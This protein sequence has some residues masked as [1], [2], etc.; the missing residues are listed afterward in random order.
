MLTYSSSRV[1]TASLFSLLGLLAAAACG[2]GGSADESNGTGSTGATAG[3]TS[4]SG[5]ATASGATANNGGGGNAGGP[6][7][8]GG[9]TGSGAA[10]NSG[11]RPAVGGYVGEGGI[12]GDYPVSPFIVVDQ[13]GYLEDS[14]KVAVLRNP[15]QGFDADGEYQTATKYQLIDAG[16]GESVLDLTAEPWDEGK[17]HSQSGDQAAWIDFSTFKTPGTY[18]V[19]DVDAE[20]RSDAFR[21][22]PDVYRE[23]LRHAL[24]TFFYQ[25]A[26]FAKKAPFADEGW[27]DEASH[28]GPKQDKNA[29]L[30]GSTGD[31][32]TERDVS[33]G[34]YDAGDYNRY[35]PWSADYVLAMLRA[36]QER[37]SA[38]GDDLNIPESG[39][40]V[41]DILDEVRFG[42][43]QLKR[44]QTDEGGCLS[45][46][47][48]DPQYSTASPPSTLTDVQAVYG[49]ETTNATI[50][51]GIAFAWAARIFKDSD[52]AFAADMLKRAE[53]AW[54]FA[55]ANPSLTFENSGKLAAGE[56]Q[57][58]PAEVE[59]YKLG[60]A[61]A[62][63]QATGTALYKQFFEDN[64]A[65]A[66]IQFLNGY[67]A[68]WQLQFTEFYLDYAA[69]AD[70]DAAI[71]GEIQSAFRDTMK[72]EG[73]LG[74]LANKPDPYLAYIDTY[75]WGSNAHKS[76]TGCLFH[77]LLTF[78]LAGDQATDARIAAERYI[79]YIHGVNPLGLVYLSNMQ[80][81]G[82]GHS[83]TQFYHAW[84]ADKSALWDQVGVSTYGPPP[85]FLTG[86]PNPSYALDG[87]CPAQDGC[88]A[89]PPSPP[90]G[91]PDMKSY[92]DFNDGWPVN[93]WAV[94]ENS[95]GYQVYY[96]RLLS[97]F[98]N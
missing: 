61:V 24:R 91:Q 56:Q 55:E 10:Q 28:V 19:L 60:F 49:P 21:V 36:Y 33:G 1:R 23:V 8:N 62:L 79:H 16:T 53:K 4:G 31:A 48:T 52:A 88:P 59:L 73:N 95:N 96:I 13:F 65:A 32:S 30:Y 2:D 14:E 93:S 84:F 25:R 46:L 22:G 20:V 90:T 89:V 69:L 66:D 11:G 64:Y 12:S 72:S 77:D 86:G 87:S 76:R 9:Q 44:T 98:V 42:I 41:S 67:N 74:M 6:G 85:G 26:G 27:T 5:S 50:R 63:Y 38:F 57:S 54:V 51:V 45:V 81:A 71:R 92:L 43:E 7:Q 18:Y 80:R 3:G 35:T 17:T 78:D 58:S 83:V 47:G 68:G 29:R 94:T 34:W 39:N 15:A 82:A 97:K 40:G 75:T 70:A 37:P